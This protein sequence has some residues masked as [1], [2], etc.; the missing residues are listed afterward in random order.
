MLSVAELVVVAEPVV[1]AELVVDA[2]E[3]PGSC[4]E[5]LPS[6][7]HATRTNASDVP[8]T[9]RKR[10][11]V[12][13]WNRSMPCPPVTA[14]RA[15]QRAPGGVDETA[16]VCAMPATPPSHALRALETG[17]FASPPRGGFALRYA[18]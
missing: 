1:V 11:T 2:A 12:S 16:T 10:R 8:K 17:G 13:R 6:P 9:T 4:D 7:P 18:Q 3:E 5:A 15:K 14:G